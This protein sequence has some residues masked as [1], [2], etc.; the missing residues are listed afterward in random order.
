MSGHERKHKAPAH[1]EPVTERRF[2]NLRDFAVQFRR[3]IRNRTSRVNGAV[4]KTALQTRNFVARETVPV[5]FGE[6]RDSIQATFLSPGNA[7]VSASSSHAAALE[8][9][10]KPHMPP[11]EA[12]I[13]WVKLRGMQGLGATTVAKRASSGRYLGGTVQDWRKSPAKR[14]AAQLKGMERGGALSVDAPTRL[15]W[16]IA[17]GI[18]K[19]DTKAQPFMAKAVPFA[20]AQLDR[21]VTEALPD[22]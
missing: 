2:D 13:A 21:F 6:V 11:I 12:I 22:R 3:D 8:F 4:K 16:Q 1:D 19:K 9:G 7:E 18:A 10:S 20:A 17:R 5:A 14:I 15:A